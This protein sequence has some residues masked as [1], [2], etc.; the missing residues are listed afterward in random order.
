MVENACWIDWLLISFAGHVE[1]DSRTT[2]LGGITPRTH[3]PDSISG[4]FLFW[5][6]A[7]DLFGEPWLYYK[8]IM[9]D[10]LVWHGKLCWGWN[11][12][13]FPFYSICLV[14]IIF[15]NCG[16]IATLWLLFEKHLMS[17][18]GFSYWI[19]MKWI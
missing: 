5:L 7:L 2:S 11:R 13:I 16:D 1:C 4:I 6:S 8:C 15:R 12:G 18:L 19:F 14:V 17:S 10:F 9:I 3:F